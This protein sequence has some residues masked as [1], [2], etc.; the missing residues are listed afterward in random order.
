MHAYKLIIEIGMYSEFTDTAECIVEANAG[1]LEIDLAMPINTYIIKHDP[2]M[3]EEIDCYFKY[4]PSNVSL[5]EREIEIKGNDGV[6]KLHKPKGMT[7]GKIK[8]SG[9]SVMVPIPELSEI[10]QLLKSKEKEDY[11]L[12]V[13]GC[14]DQLNK[15]SLCDQD[16]CQFLNFL[17]IALKKLGNYQEAQIKFQTAYKLKNSVPEAIQ[18]NIEK[19]IKVNGSLL[20][21]EM[22]DG[23]ENSSTQESKS[24]ELE[25]LPELDIFNGNTQENSEFVS[26][27]QAL[28]LSEQDLIND[29]IKL[30]NEDI[31][32]YNKDGVDEVSN[33]WLVRGGGTV[34]A[35]I[36][37]YDKYMVSMVSAN[38]AR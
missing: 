3:K 15:K 29:E 37:F 36:L 7:W 1:M 38:P 28:I 24:H 23:L 4:N 22:Y 10:T 32:N 8:W 2:L 19:N 33:R 18:K 5:L 14:S 11:V 6:L 16:K 21:Q 20:L 35:S 12:V 27:I 13:N 17:G 26:P 31:L 9:F 25:I 34:H 30:I